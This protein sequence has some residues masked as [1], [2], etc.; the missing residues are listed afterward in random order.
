[1]VEDKNIAGFEIPRPAKEE[2]VTK[3]YEKFGLGK[4]PTLEEVEPVATKLLSDTATF[5]AGA[6]LV[7]GRRVSSSFEE[8]PEVFPLIY[9]PGFEAEDRFGMLLVQRATEDLKDK[10]SQK[11]K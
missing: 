11:Q 5:Q 1:M 3:Q 7:L 6:E 10:A 2:W 9:T 8:E 4:S